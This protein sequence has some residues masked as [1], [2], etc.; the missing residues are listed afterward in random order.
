MS[1]VGILHKQKIAATTAVTTDRKPVNISKRLLPLLNIQIR[2]FSETWAVG[3]VLRLGFSYAVRC[4]GNTKAPLSK[5]CGV[6]PPLPSSI[7]GGARPYLEA[8]CLL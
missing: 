5:G 3:M 2:R 6:P 4:S 7:A 1:M 8:A